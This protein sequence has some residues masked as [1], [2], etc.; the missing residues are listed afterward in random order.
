MTTPDNTN[1]VPDMIKHEQLDP[2]PKH[3]F[4]CANKR[5]RSSILAFDSPLN[6]PNRCLCTWAT[7]DYDLQ[8]ADAVVTLLGSMEPTC[9]NVK[10]QQEVYSKISLFREPRANSEEIVKKLELIR[11]KPKYAFCVEPLKETNNSGCADAC[12]MIFIIILTIFAGGFLGWII[13]CDQVPTQIG[14]QLEALNDERHSLI[15]QLKASR[16]ETETLQM[17]FTA[18]KDRMERFCEPMLD[19]GHKTIRIDSTGT[20]IYHGEARIL[21]G[22]EK[23]GLSEIL[24]VAV[25]SVITAVILVLLK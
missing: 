24:T 9:V 21:S 19:G 6:E 3:K 22:D 16:N 11:K 2:K 20:T 23:T 13:G 8:D 17:Q 12:F 18:Y 10:M 1:L 14:K 4:N 15:T 7:F 5:C 25:C